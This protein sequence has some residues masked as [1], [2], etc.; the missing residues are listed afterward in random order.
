MKNIVILSTSEYEELVTYKTHLAL[1]INS[2]KECSTLT[3]DE[4]LMIDSY[5][6][7][8]A[9]RYSIPPTYKDIVQNLRSEENLKNE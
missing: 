3:L 6:L 4:Q 5:E 1:L 7:A 9:L 8:K 2:I